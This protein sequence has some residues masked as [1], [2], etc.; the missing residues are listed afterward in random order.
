[1][2]HN[3]LFTFFLSKARQAKTEHMEMKISKPIIGILVALTKNEVMKT[4]NEPSI[5]CEKHLKVLRLYECWN[6]MW[7]ISNLN[8]KNDMASLCL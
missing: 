6:Q 5:Y 2:L 3:S 1:M 7:V 8:F 4:R